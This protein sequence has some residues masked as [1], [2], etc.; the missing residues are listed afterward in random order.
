MDIHIDISQIIFNRI[1]VSSVGTLIKNLQKSELFAQCPHCYQEFTLSKSIM[2]DGRSKFP[3]EAEEKRQEY[4]SEL[5]QRLTDLKNRKIK[6]DTGAEKTAIA[7]GIGK[8]I[9]K[10]L[11]AYKNFD[12][13]LPDCRFLADPIDMIVFEGASNL[14]VNH[15]TFMDIKTGNARLNGHQKMIRDAIE[16]ND[17]RC[18]VI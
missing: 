11:P 3:S 10:V 18:K 16:D 4:Q 8:N 13:A 1:M 6:A 9:E 5:N 14:K 2:F 17:V 7:V 12:K 15:I